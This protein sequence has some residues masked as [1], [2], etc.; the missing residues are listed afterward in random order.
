MTDR[1]KKSTLLW[2]ERTERFPHGLITELATGYNPEGV[3][4]QLHIALG[5]GTLYMKREGKTYS[6]SLRKVCDS[7]FDQ[8]L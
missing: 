2:E 5:S 4:F 3:P 6:L 8:I 7:F 1:K